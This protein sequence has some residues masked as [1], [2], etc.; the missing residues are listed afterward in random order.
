MRSR[1]KIACPEP[2]GQE[3]PGPEKQEL[4]QPSRKER[5]WQGARAGPQEGGDALRLPGALT[6]DLR[7]RES[8]PHSTAEVPKGLQRPPGRAQEQLGGSSGC[9]SGQRGLRGPGA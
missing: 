3:S 9:G 6:E 8:T 5:H 1:A 7:P 4:Y 2:P